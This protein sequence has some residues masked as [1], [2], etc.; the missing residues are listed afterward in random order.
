MNDFTA[1]LGKSSHIEVH[2]NH[3]EIDWKVTVADTGPTTMTGGRINKVK[4]YIVGERF[5]CTYGDGLADIN[6][7]ALIQFHKE[8]RKTATVTAVRPTNRFGAMHIDKN[9]LV[10]EFAEKPISEKRVNG[11]YFIFEPSIF[12]HLSD[13]SV[14]EKDPLEKLSE[15]GELKAYLHDGFWQPMDTYRETTELN[16]LWD[17]NRA[18][19]KIW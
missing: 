2:G 14:L 13:E 16:E 1:H 19:W 15:S 12:N 8:H 4:K 17:A 18:P 6:L 9:N 10:T 7:D 11:G 3:E 5:L